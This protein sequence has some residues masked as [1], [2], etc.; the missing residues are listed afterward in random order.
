MYNATVQ[1]L[2]AV[3]NNRMT[4]DDAMARIAE[5]LKTKAR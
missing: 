4:M 1:F 3:M 5:E 2:A